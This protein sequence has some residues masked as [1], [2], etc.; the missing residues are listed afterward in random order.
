[1]KKQQISLHFLLLLFFSLSIPLTVALGDNITLNNGDR[2]TGKIIKMDRL[3]L[4]IK[5][6]YAGEI[7]VARENISS[8]F[9]D[10]PATI[11]FNDSTIARFNIEAARD[12]FPVSKDENSLEIIPIDSIA[13]INPPPEITDT[14]T[15]F[16]GEFNVGGVRKGGNTISDDWNFDLTTRF[17]KGKSRYLING[18]ATYESK[19][20]E[21]TELKWFIQGRSN[22]FYDEN[23]YG[24]GNFAY[25]FD[26]FKGIDLRLISGIGIGYQFLDDKDH[27][28]SAE[29]GPNFVCEK[30]NEK[31]T[32]YYSAARWAF[33]FKY[34]LYLKILKFYHN[35]SIL[36]GLDNIDNLIIKT[37]TGI[38]LPIA[39]LNIQTA[40]QFDWDWENLPDP[41]KE[42]NDTRLIIKGGYSW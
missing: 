11:M 36:L 3:T 24:L 30:E 31:D 22:R 12:P 23:W 5:T 35:H 27:H 16:T 28:I 2:L 1:M 32:T 6:D 37:S 42:K 13:Y 10:E 18:T 9:T 40:I 25:E 14:G 15:F 17:D 39:L 4:A 29:L 19:D 8:F 38:S 34:P 26:K 33:S 7:K 41:G 20:N 21:D